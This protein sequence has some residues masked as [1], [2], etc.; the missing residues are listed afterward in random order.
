MKKTICVIG[1]GH[2][3]TRFLADTLQSSGVYMGRELNPSMD[4]GPYHKFF[5]IMDMPAEYILSKTNSPN[6][7]EWDFSRM[8]NEPIPLHFV[9]EMKGYLEDI[10]SYGGEAVGWK[11]TESNLVYPWLVRLYPDWYYIHLVRD[12][13][14]CFFRPEQSD[15]LKHTESFNIPE[16]VPIRNKNTPPE[17]HML[18][19]LNWK[20]QIDI[21]KSISPKNYMRLTLEDLV[22][23]QDEKLYEL[24][25]FLGFQL[26]KLPAK[27]KV[28]ESWRLNKSESY[29]NV[30]GRTPSNFDS[31]LY[32]FL[33]DYMEEFKYPDW[34][35]L[36]DNKEH[37]RK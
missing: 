20:Y 34:P 17:N 3:G 33:D 2:S 23:K 15:T 30:T 13:R 22:M 35:R 9:D 31:N 6:N 14:D 25:H 19:A 28:V 16:Y 32:P 21:V 5:D 37:R 4:K 24:L 7:S 29:T 27:K 10:E 12:V 26:E 18:S 8:L 36:G 11:L 1:K